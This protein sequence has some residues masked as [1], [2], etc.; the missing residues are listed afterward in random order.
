MFSG[1][2]S[3]RKAP[4]LSAETLAPSCYKG[5]FEGCTSLKE[6]PELPSTILAPSCYTY[7]FAGCFGLIS[8]YEGENLS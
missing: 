2:T 6:V 4:K 5:M 3:L 7:M 1:C 8:N